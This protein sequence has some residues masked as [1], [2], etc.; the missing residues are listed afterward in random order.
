VWLRHAITMSAEKRT[1]RWAIR[2]ESPTPAELNGLESVVRQAGAGVGP[3]ACESAVVELCE[4][5]DQ[6]RLHYPYRDGME[7]ARSSI[8]EARA[9]LAGLTVVFRDAA[10]AVAKLP[11]SA[12]KAFARATGVPLG[13]THQHLLALAQSASAQFLESTKVPDR[14]EDSAR[15]V[16]AFD[17][18]RILSRTLKV[19]VSMTSDRNTS[20]HARGGAAYCRLL[21]ATLQAAGTDPPSELRPVMR[22]GVSLLK[23][24]G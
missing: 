22:E 12:K 5:I 6:F 21:R 14:D 11:L 20:G 8:S 4:A 15:A 18:A 19:K 3:A 16:L 7:L 1:R 17:V 13:Q 2:R 24:P 10:D 9:A 23:D